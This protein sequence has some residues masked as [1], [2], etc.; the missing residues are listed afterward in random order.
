MFPDGTIPGCPPCPDCA[1][2][3]ILPAPSGISW[4]GIGV[5]KVPGTVEVALLEHCLREDL[6]QN[7]PRAMA[8][9]RPVR[10]TITN[11][12]EGESETFSTDINPAHPEAGTRPVAFSRHLWIEREDFLEEPVKGYFRLYPGNEVRLKSAYV[13]RCTGCVKDDRGNVT[14]VLAEYDPATRGGNTPDG[15]RIKG[16]IHWVER[17]TAVDA[18][19]AAVRQPFPGSQ[20]RRRG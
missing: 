8:V 18:R 2:G 17:A 10:L 20:S 14:E 15:R 3:G 1:A 4:I 19:G 6:N 11:Y 9:L 13:I 16:T 5:A 7:A 12:P